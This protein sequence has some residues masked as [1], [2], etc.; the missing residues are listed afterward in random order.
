MIDMNLNIRWEPILKIVGVRL[1]VA[2]GVLELGNCLF[3]Q[4]RAQKTFFWPLMLLTHGGCVFFPLAMR[5]LSLQAGLYQ[6][7]RWLITLRRRTTFIHLSCHEHM[8][9]LTSCLPLL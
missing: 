1:R 7:R 8:P 4:E 3:R 9:L 5:N 6:L 2:F